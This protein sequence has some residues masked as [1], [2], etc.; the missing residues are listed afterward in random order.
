MHNRL[1][2]YSR[3]GGAITCH[4]VRASGCFFEQLRTHVLKGVSKRYFFGDGHPIIDHG[5]G[6]ELL[7]EGDVAAFGTKRHLDGLG[8]LVDPSLEGVT[9]R[10]RR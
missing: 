4:I 6:A 7:V 2:Q 1:C 3:R 10:R 8:E 9:S 5:G